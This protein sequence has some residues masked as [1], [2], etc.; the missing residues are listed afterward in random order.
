MSM[1]YPNATGKTNLYPLLSNFS[2]S[3]N[4]GEVAT[5]NGIPEVNSASVR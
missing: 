3:I 5:M 2:L 1:E 4:F